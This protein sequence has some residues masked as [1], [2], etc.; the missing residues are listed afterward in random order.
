MKTARRFAVIFTLISLSLL[1]IFI[2]MN[3]ED[4]TNWWKE[5]V[6][7]GSIKIIPTGK[8]VF[9][10]DLKPLPSECKKVGD[11]CWK[12][13]SSSSVVKFIQ[14]EQNGQNIVVGVYKQ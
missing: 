7:N 5:G 3:K 13:N 4:N 12:N 11:D 8:M 1:V 6:S 10:E 2:T 14:Y 9:V